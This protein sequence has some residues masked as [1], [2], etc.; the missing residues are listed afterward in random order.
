MAG[1]ENY[2]LSFEYVPDLSGLHLRCAGGRLYSPTRIRRRLV[3]YPGACTM[4]VAPV[5]D[6]S[7]RKKTV[8]RLRY[9]AEV[10]VYPHTLQLYYS[11]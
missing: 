4:R 11:T 10:G 9:T 1:V 6:R 7:N 3:V 5:E 2:E 8:T